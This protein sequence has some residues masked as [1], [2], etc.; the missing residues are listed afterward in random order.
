VGTVPQ[1]CEAA[2]IKEAVSAYR[3][4]GVWVGCKAVAC[5]PAT[6]QYDEMVKAAMARTNGACSAPG[7][8]VQG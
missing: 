6:Q 1:R 8:L 5:N 4:I 7:D 2:T 3:R